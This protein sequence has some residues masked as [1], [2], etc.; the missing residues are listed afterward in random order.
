MKWI[1]QHIWD[2]IS[3]FRSDVYLEAIESGTIASG[4]NLGLDSNNKIVKASEVGGAVDLTSEVTGV[5]P[6][7]NG[8]S[9]ASS[10]TDNSV[11]TGTGASPITAEANFTYSGTALSINAL[12]ST[13][14][15]ATNSQV[16]IKNT[17]NNTAGG[18]LD[19]I[20][21]R[22]TGVDGDTA[23]AIRFYG[24]NDSGTSVKVVEFS[25]QI[26]ETAAG[27][28]KGTF[29]IT[30]RDASGNAMRNVILAES[31]AS[32]VVDVQLGY[33]PASTTT[34]A[35]DLDIDGDNMTSAGAMTFTPVGKYT[36]AA[37]DLSDVVFHLDANADTDNIVDIDAGRLDI[38]SSENTSITAVGTAELAGSTVTLDSAGNIELEVAGALNYVNTNGIFRGGNI[39]PV[40]ETFIPLMPVDFITASSYRQVGEIATPSNGKT[41]APSNAGTFYFCQKIIPKGYT[42]STF[43]ING[44]DGGST[45]ATFTAYQ[46]VID[47]TTP[48]AATLA[49]AF[50]TDQSVI[51][52]KEIVGDG[53]KFVT[54]VFNPGDTSDLIYGGK[55]TIAKTT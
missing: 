27:S 20:N 10:L 52:G 4:G 50:N 39:G 16:I 19:F 11:L 18:V 54:I 28:E 14:T 37:P 41:M 3:R 36:I 33:G 40:S 22:G 7:A 55:I 15:N 2:F 5:L 43:R 30:A 8:G 49:F 45:A 23:G 51:T 53:E 26:A 34:I 1:G 25:S 9:G 35:G 32:D 13:F 12:T 44:T 31:L 21:E 42:A 47:G 17:G 6:V 46:C 24:D 29:Q 38:D 48:I